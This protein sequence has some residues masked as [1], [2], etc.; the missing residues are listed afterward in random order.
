[1]AMLRIVAAMR[2]QRSAVTY[3]R[4]GLVDAVI[5]HSRVRPTPVSQGFMKRVN[6]SASKRNEA[7]A[8]TRMA[9]QLSFA[10]LMLSPLNFGVLQ[11]IGAK[12][13]AGKS[14]NVFL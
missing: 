5:N 4:A 14:G 13:T 12:L 8:A 11:R 2:E 1:M 3:G 6:Q 10:L 7:T 9:I